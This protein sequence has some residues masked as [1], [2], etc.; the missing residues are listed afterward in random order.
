MAIITLTTDWGTKDHYLAIVKGSLLS[1]IPDVQIIDITHEVLPFD[2]YQASFV[3]K[4]SY[5]HF[6]DGTI[7]IIGINSDASI[8]RPH[9]AIHYNNQYFIGADNGVFSL[10]FGQQP[11]DIVELEIIQDTDKYTFS[12][13]DV[14]VKAARHLALGGDFVRLGN[15]RNQINKLMSFEPIIEMDEQSVTIIGK[16]IYIDR[17][18]NATT[19]ISEALFNEYAKNRAFDIT[20]NSFSGELTSISKS[21]LDVPPSEMCAL[22]DSNGMLEIS[23]NQGNAGSL[24]GL[25]VDSRIRIN[26]EK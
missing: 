5:Q 18:E 14:F 13:K 26:I 22:F 2:I 23:I 24:L 15:H 10:I 9:I 25:K 16:V 3:F 12:T 11:I 19:N 17:Y 21:Y 6:P 4:N 8:D 1:K 20:F 7:H